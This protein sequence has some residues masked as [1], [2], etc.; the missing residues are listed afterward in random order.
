MRHNIFHSL[1]VAAATVG[2][3]TS[4]AQAATNC[5]LGEAVEWTAF[6]GHDNDFRAE[7]SMPN[8]NFHGLKRISNFERGDEPCR[9]ES[10]FGRMPEATRAKAEV[11]RV[12]DNCNG[13]ARDRISVGFDDRLDGAFITGIK[14]WTSNQGN[15]TRRRLKGLT[16]EGRI[17]DN[18]S[19]GLS[20][21]D[22]EAWAEPQGIDPDVARSPLT[23]QHTRNHANREH[24]MVQCP[25][26]WVASG[27]QLAQGDRGISG[28]RL[29]CREVITR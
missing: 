5:R 8:A 13:N 9:T 3:L 11:Q 28:L 12:T 29:Q 15:A 7:L 20:E 6:T 16:A 19:C 24:S 21:F 17:V 2:V 23:T 1:L 18:Q 4:A 27:F 26:G 10:V 22:F 25:D 14:A